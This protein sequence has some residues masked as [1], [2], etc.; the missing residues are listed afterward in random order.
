LVIVAPASRGPTWAILISDQDL[1]LQ[2]VDLVAAEGFE[3]CRIDRSR[4]AIGG[5]SDGATYALTLGIANGDLFPAIIALSPGGI[6][7]NER[8]GAPR[9]FVSHGIRDAVLPIAGAGDAIVRQLEGADYDVTY[10]RFRGGHEVEPA[11][12][13]AAARWFLTGLD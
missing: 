8:R 1:D 9:V 10:R 2:S 6:L 11:T 13:A 4:I 5:F 7:A 3:R 12:S